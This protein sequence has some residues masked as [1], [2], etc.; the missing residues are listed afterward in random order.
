MS[1]DSGWLWLIFIVFVGVPLAPLFFGAF[2][3]LIA[4]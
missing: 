3:A 2:I 1:E 4:H